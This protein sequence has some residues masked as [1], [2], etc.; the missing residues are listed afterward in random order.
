D[1]ATV[2]LLSPCSGPPAVAGAWLA[3][4]V[5]RYLDGGSFQVA[6]VALAILMLV[7]AALWLKAEPISD[8]MLET[9][10]L[11]VLDR[12][13]MKTRF[14]QFALLPSYWLSAGVLQW[15]EGAWSGAG[16][17][18]LVL[19]S[20]SRFFGCLAFTRMGGPFY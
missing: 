14:A 18:A 5:A 3:V 9:R 11:A 15:S 19:L 1:P 7:V 8:E 2:V 16:F 12:L 10:V 4:S 6:A 20:H 13:L 17:F